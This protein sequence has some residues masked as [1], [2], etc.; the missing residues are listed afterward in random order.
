MECPFCHKTG[1]KTLETRECPENITR[2]RKMCLSCENR[3]TT[4]EH[5]EVDP[6]MVIKSDGSRQPY[7]T[8]K[9]LSGIYRACEK[10]PV[11]EEE[12]QA[13]ADAVYAKILSKGKREIKSK[14]IGLYT[15][16]RLKKVDKIA[17]MRF[18]SVFRGFENVEQFENELNKFQKAAAPTEGSERT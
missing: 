5:I 13:I 14:K 10:R 3:F 16:N 17:Y 6:I 2:R 15:L 18:A 8:Q 1:I 7:D 11:S 4:Y 9:V 12:I